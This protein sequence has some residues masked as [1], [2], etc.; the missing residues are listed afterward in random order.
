MLFMR[1]STTL[2]WRRRSAAG[3][4]RSDADGNAALH[5]RQSAEAALSCGALQ[6][7]FGLGL[8]RGAERK[9]WE[10]GDG[11]PRH[12]GGHRGCYT[13]KPTYEEVCSGPYLTPEA[14]GVVSTW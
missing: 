12:R 14:V 8:S 1:K 7:V 6:A 10:L 9:F 3:P 5:Q 2:A 13:P 11:A 4:S